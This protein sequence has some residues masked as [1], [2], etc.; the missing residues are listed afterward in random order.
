[1]NDKLSSFDAAFA[2]SKT[3]GNE[4]NKKIKSLT[5]SLDQ[6]NDEVAR[7]STALNQATILESKKDKE[8]LRLR[9]SP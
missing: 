7:L 2:K 6:L 5:K 9:A 3:K 1:M 8:I 4:R